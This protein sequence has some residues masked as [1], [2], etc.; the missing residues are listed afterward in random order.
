MLSYIENMSNRC[1]RDEQKKEDPASSVVTATLTDHKASLQAV[2]DAAFSKLKTKLDYIQ[3]VLLDH[4][5]RFSSLEAS[6]TTTRQ[7][8]Q[9]MEMKLTAVAKEHHA[10]S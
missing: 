4:Q 7:D 8:V 3:V 9:A 10:E 5:Q 2:F 1:R 6:A